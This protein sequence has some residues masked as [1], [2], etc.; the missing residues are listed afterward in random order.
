[1]KQFTKYDRPVK[2]PEINEGPVITEVKG[3]ISPKTQVERLIRSGERLMEY[4]RQM[5]DAGIDDNFDDIRLDPTRSP[6]FD[7][8]D[9]SAIQAEL[10]SKRKKAE[11]KVKEKAI[12]ESKEEPESEEVAPGETQE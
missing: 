10:S 7:L 8:A 5:Y 11:M 9:A 1:M 2:S 12:P 4:R 6:D 3:Y